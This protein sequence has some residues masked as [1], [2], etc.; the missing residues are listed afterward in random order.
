M[1]HDKMQQNTALLCGKS[2]SAY[3]TKNFFTTVIQFTRTMTLKLPT[4]YM[5]SQHLWWDR[6]FAYRIFMLQHAEAMPKPYHIDIYNIFGICH[7]AKPHCVVF[8]CTAWCRLTFTW[9]KKT[10]RMLASVHFVWRELNGRVLMQFS[11]KN[12]FLCF[13]ESLCKTFRTSLAHQFQGRRHCKFKN[14]KFLHLC[15]FWK[16][17]C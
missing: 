8:C 12:K 10:A 15:G 7:T 14:Q 11:F 6:H 2:C 13:Y 5:Q 17:L 3:A 16:F 1:L 9:N 4:H